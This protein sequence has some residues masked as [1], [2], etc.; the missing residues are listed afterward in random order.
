[1]SLHMKERIDIQIL[2]LS[3]A[4]IVIMI[5]LANGLAVGGGF[6][7]FLTLLGVAPRLTQLTKT[8][9]YVHYYIWALVVGAQCGA[10]ASLHSF[11]FH[12]SG[13]WTIVIGL[14]AG[15]FIGM[16]AA[17]LTEVLNVI[18]IVVKRIG[19]YDRIVYLLMALAIGKIC[20][21]LFQW[22]FFE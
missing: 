20:G 9:K 22:L 10:W 1:M 3:K 15:M 21:S 8:K 7:A 6:V 18:P 11:T 16:L 2:L 5:G 17:A 19:L 12:F 4:L 13:L 14:M